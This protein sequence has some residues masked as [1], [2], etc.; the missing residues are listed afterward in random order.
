M[1]I[2]GRRQRRRR[3]QI[4]AE[5]DHNGSTALK[6]KTKGLPCEQDDNSQAG[7]RVRYSGPDLPEDILRHIHSLMPLRDAARAACVSHAFLHSW[8]CHPNLIFNNKEFCFKKEYANGWNF[9]SKI[10]HILSNHSGIGVTIFRLEFWGL[11]KYNANHYLKSWLQVAVTP[12]IEELTLMLFKVKRMYKLRCS[13]LSNG[14]RDSIQKLQ[15]GFCAFH[16]TAELGPFRSLINLH[17]HTVRITEDELG[18]LL[19]NSFALQRLELTWCN[20]IICL[21]IPCVLLHLSSLKVFVWE[22]L[23]LIESKA[24]NLSNLSLHGKQVKLI[25]GETLKLKSV[26]MSHSNLVSHARAN[27][28]ASMPN[29]ET[30]AISS[31]HEM[32]NTPL[33]PTKFL[34]LKHLA[35]SLHG[36]MLSPSYDYFSLVSFLDASPSLETL[37]LNLSQVHMQ[38]ESI[39]KDP[40]SHLRQMPEHPLDHLKSVKIAGFSSAKSLVELTCHIVKNAASLECLTLDAFYGFRCADKK[41]KRCY[42]INED[43]SEPPRALL[44]IRRYIEDKVPSTVKLNV[45]EPCSRCHAKEC[46]FVAFMLLF[47]MD[48]YMALMR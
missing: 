19:S 27:F 29:L 1:Y 4:Q 12:G 33:L 10:N 14:V 21:N 22:R 47:T 6:G 34:Y 40:T 16:P 25:L 41:S 13:L 38:Q 39:F 44:A 20:Q 30:L 31:C 43:L 35:I 46:V 24:P 45:V 8:R 28:P 23:K 48:T 37:V 7:K 26:D 5:E 17:L 42:V 3:W 32:I 9:C 11:S 18:C 2:R 36:W 15:L